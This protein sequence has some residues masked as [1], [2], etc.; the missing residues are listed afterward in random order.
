M[1]RECFAR[2]KRFV[3]LDRRVIAV[4]GLN[5]DHPRTSLAG[6]LTELVYQPGR[7]A[8]CTGYLA[9]ELKNLIILNADRQKFPQ[10]G[11]FRFDKI[12]RN[13]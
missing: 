7:D 6:Y 4:V 5:I 1:R 8:A 11:F 9:I 3:K 13:V 10:F 12:L 2:A